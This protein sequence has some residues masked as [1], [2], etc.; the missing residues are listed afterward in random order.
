[1]SSG[2]C[3]VTF[4]EHLAPVTAVKFAGHGA[5]K[6]ILSSSLDGTVRAH[7]LLRYKNFRTLTSP[8]CISIHHKKEK[9]IQIL[10]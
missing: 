2:Y 1:M 5:S 7:D 8:V 6:A 9:H 3:F 10:S 4:T